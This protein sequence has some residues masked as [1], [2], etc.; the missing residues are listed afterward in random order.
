MIFFFF[1]RNIK[2]KLLLV[3]LLLHFSPFRTQI[4][5]ILSI[6]TSILLNQGS[7]MS[8]LAGGTT[9]YVQGSGFDPILANNQVFI[10]NSVP[11]VLLSNFPSILP[12]NVFLGTTTAYLV[13]KTPTILSEGDYTLNITIPGIQVQCLCDCRNFYRYSNKHPSKKK[14]IES[15]NI[16]KVSR[17]NFIKYL[18]DP[19]FPEHL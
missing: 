13:I 16:F 2:E 10:N 18:R 14:N 3:L 17:L 19:E 8:S 4:A 6:S 7:Q 5:Q 12:L 11:A 9:L 1:L 15:N